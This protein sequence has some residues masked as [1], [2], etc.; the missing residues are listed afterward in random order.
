[1]YRLRIFDKRINVQRV[2]VHYRK[3]EQGEPTGNR[4]QKVVSETKIS[5]Q[6][7]YK[8]QRKSEREKLK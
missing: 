6:K 3:E 8:S 1:M 5:K 4:N 7:A 2:Q